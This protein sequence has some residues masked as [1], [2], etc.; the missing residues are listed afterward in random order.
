MTR[1]TSVDCKHCRLLP[2][3]G[4]EHLFCGGPRGPVPLRQGDIL[5]TRRLGFRHLVR[6][7]LLKLVSLIHIR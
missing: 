1:M 2:L 3:L 6:C 4:L 5:Y 7:P